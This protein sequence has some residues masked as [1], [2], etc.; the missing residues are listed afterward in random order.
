[1]GAQRTADASLG[2]I[3]EV[4]GVMQPPGPVVVPEVVQAVALADADGQ[5]GG[6]GAGGG[7]VGVDHVG[8]GEKDAQHDQSSVGTVFSLSALISAPCGSDD[9]RGPGRA[10]LVQGRLAAALL[11]MRLLMNCRHHG[12]TPGGWQAGPALQSVIRKRTSARQATLACLRTSTTLV[13]DGLLPL[14]Q[15]HS[16]RQVSPDQYLKDRDFG[17]R[18]PPGRD[19]Q[20]A[21]GSGRRHRRASRQRPFLQGEAFQAR[22]RRGSDRRFGLRRARRLRLRALSVRVPQVPGKGLEPSRL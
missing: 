4:F 10:R 1:M 22:V 21:Q 14:P 12:R 6:G 16:D 17:F 3:R 19:H 2:E 20:R 8:G 11:V 9:H 18:R 5:L 13:G 7:V 15:S